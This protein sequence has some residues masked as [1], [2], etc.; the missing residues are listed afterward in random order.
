MI[1][2]VHSVRFL[3][4]YGHKNLRVLTDNWSPPEGGTCLN[5][6]EAINVL[7]ASAKLRKAT[8]SF[9]MYVSMYVCTQE[10]TPLPL[11]GFS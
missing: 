8:I 5:C 10:T 3:V 11:D 1:L 7:T 9:D 4:I 2:L 6:V